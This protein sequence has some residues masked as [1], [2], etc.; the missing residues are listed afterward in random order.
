VSWE[1]FEGSSIQAKHV[2][3]KKQKNQPER[4]KS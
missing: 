2:Q 4:R 3:S 1:R